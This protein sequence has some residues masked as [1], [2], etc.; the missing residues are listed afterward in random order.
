MVETIIN[1]PLNHHYFIGAMWP[2]S[3]V[4]WFRFAPVTSSLFAHHVYHSE[5]GV[6]NAPAERYRG[7]GH[8]L[9][10]VY[11]FMYIYNHIYIY[12]IMGTT[13]Y[14]LKSGWFIVLPTTKF[15]YDK[16]IPI[17]P[18]CAPIR[19]E[20]L[21]KSHGFPVDFPIKPWISWEFHMVQG[22]ATVR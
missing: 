14:T 2:P 16:R 5:I 18:P 11:I 19:D 6:I 7:R 12:I 13:L 21:A 1:H 9:V 4:C 10:Y 8:H 22:G 20:G 3:D 15:P 17:D